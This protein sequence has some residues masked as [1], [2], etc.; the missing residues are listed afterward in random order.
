MRVRKG[1][2]QKVNAIGKESF[3]EAEDRMNE[4]K[5]DRRKSDFETL[6]MDKFAVVT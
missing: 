3:A 1:D 5:K 2:T 4:R 6:S